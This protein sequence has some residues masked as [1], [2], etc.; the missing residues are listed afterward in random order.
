MP[1]Y[2][3]EEK[4]SGRK[5]VV[6]AEDAGQAAGKAFLDME[7]DDRTTFICRRQGEPERH[8]EVREDR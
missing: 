7:C 2:K 6:D 5:L 4:S 3:V 8:F 1:E